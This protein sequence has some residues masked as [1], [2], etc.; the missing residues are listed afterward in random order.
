MVLSF[1]SPTQLCSPD[2][3]PTPQPL[4]GSLGTRSQ[5]GMAGAKHPEGSHG[6]SELLS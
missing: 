1:N 4:A 2:M 6:C 5:Q 3:T